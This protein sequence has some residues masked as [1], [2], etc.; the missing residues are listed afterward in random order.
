MKSYHKISNLILCKKKFYKYFLILG[1]CGKTNQKSRRFPEPNELGMLHTRKK[2]SKHPHIPSTPLSTKFYFF[3]VFNRPLGRAAITNYEWFSKTTT[4]AVRR[5]ANLNR[6]SSTQTCILP[7]QYVCLCWTKRRIG[8]RPS[9][10]NRYCWAFR[11]CWTSLT[12][13]IRHKQRLTLSIGE[14]KQFEFFLW[15]S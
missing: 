4:R 8:G 15:W 3:C 2:R 1:L 9:Q 10:S 5:N 6:H 12:W 11:I 13:K 7:A 14:E